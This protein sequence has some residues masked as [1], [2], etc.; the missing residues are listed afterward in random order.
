MPGTVLG[1]PQSVAFP[2]SQDSA[3][4]CKEEVERRDAACTWNV[5]EKDVFDMTVLWRQCDGVQ[6][7]GDTPNVNVV[8]APTNVDSGNADAG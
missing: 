7:K 8:D 5:H 3:W 6:D 1:V 2:T 4:T